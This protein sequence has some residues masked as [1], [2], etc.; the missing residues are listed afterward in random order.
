VNVALVAPSP[1]P[2]AFGGVERVLLGLPEAIAALTPH[3]VEVVKLPAAEATFWDLVDGYRRFWA[4]DLRHFDVVVSLK[5]PAWMV[6]HPHHVCYLQHRARSLYD[7]YPAELGTDVPDRLSAVGRLTR[8]MDE[9]AGEGH[10]ALPRFFELVEDL[11]D[12]APLL[13][14]ETFRRPGPLVRRVVHWLDGVALSPR[15]IRRFVAISRVVADRP[16]YFPAGVAVDVAP[17][18]SRLRGLHD[19]G[20]EYLLAP[21]RLDAPKRIDLLVRALRLARTRRPLLVAGTGPDEAALRE[22]AAGDDRVRFLGFVSDPDLVTLYARALAVLFV[23]YDEDHGLVPLEA[24]ASRKPVVTCDDSGGPLEYVT[25]GETGLVTQATPE[26]L[27][28]AIDRLSDDPE[29]ARRMGARGAE[30]VRDVTWARAVEALLGERLP[31]VAR[32]AARTARPAA[33]RRI[34]VAVPYDVHPPLA[35]GTERLFQLWRGIAEGFDVELVTLGDHGVPPLEAE[36]APGLREIRVPK[37]A[38]YV[39][40]EARLA[41]GAGVSVD[42]MAPALLAG[43][44]PDY[45]GFLAR[46]AAGAALVAAAHP[47]SFPALRAAHVDAPLVYHAHDVEVTLKADTLPPDLLR[48]VRTVEAE[49]CTAARLLVVCSRDD[50]DQLARLYGVDAARFHVAP[51]GVDTR[52]IAMTDPAARAAR[53]RAMGLA[54][55]RIAIFVGSRHPPNVEAAEFVLE[56]AAALPEVTFLLVGGQ[57]GALTDRPR[58]Q[59]V[60]LMGV[61]DAATFATL[62]AV[63]DVALN[64]MRSGSGTNVKLAG[65]FAAGVPV[66]TTP[67]GA[68]GYDLADREHAIVAPLA[69]F[70]AAVRAVLNDAGLAA[71]LAADARRLAET[72]YDWGT[73]AAGVRVAL[74]KLLDGAAR[75]LPASTAAVS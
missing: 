34:T 63:A 43:L 41:R 69:E 40:E 52:A 74:E 75:D 5:Y 59:N 8:Y 68:R 28:R 32:V 7:L 14:A 21:G 67:M 19:A 57:C 60:A 29:A 33:R 36:I 26:A 70:A 45:T 35:G 56:L 24:M 62:A 9:H 47:Y 22:L 10:D 64:P 48:A 46:S 53:R 4:L 31:Q 6:R 39:A 50:A 27:A 49:V 72:R 54:D 16:G 71:R 44:V 38:R 42:D 37:S 18:V 23:P 65:Y 17:T 58:P 25:D 15:A 30:R 12:A 20:A 3:Q 66:V 1:V 61:V 55:A 73:I 51:N 11:R 13:P 2:F